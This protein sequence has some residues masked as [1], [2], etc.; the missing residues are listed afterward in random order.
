MY[1]S[2]EKKGG[3][4]GWGEAHQNMT[5]LCARAGGGA[6]RL[7]GIFRRLSILSL[8]LV[9]V[10]GKDEVAGGVVPVTGHCG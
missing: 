6:P 5:D 9:V 3:G 2:H 1:A 7:L 10:A 4:G 8:L